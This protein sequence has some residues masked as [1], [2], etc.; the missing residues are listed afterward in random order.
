MF[1]PAEVIDITARARE[2]PDAKVEIKEI[3]DHERRYGRL[4]ARALV[5]MNSEWAGKV[6]DPDAFKGVD[7]AGAFHFPGFSADA[8]EFLLERRQISG[9]AVDTL[10]IDGAVNPGSPVH[11]MVLGSDLYTLENLAHLSRIPRSGAQL[12]IGVVPYEAG[13]GGPCRIIAQV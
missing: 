10:S 13:S 7:P 4:P 2:D 9:V 3:R 6:G 5:T 11:H 12:F 8:A 1:V